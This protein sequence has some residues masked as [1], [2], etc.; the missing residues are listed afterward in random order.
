ML[1]R[2]TNTSHLPALGR[3]REAL[4]PALDP[5]PGIY[6]VRNDHPALRLPASDLSAGINPLRSGGRLKQEGVVQPRDTH[7]HKQPFTTLSDSSSHSPNFCALSHPGPSLDLLPSVLT[8]VLTLNRTS[9]PYIRIRRTREAK[10]LPV[11][12]ESISGSHIRQPRQ[13]VLYSGHS[14]P[15]RRRQVY[16]ALQPK[17]L[18]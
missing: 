14:T 3:Y 7:T 4:A 2:A 13:H 9:E 18:A 10:G 11:P 17:S 15:R 8:L 16:L 12:T 5:S 1:S 6:R